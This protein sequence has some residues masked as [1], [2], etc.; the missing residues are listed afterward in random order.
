[1]DRCK[2]CI[3]SYIFLSTLLLIQYFQ[4]GTVSDLA[5][6]LEADM[7]EGAGFY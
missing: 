7:Y 2:I 4:N 6:G 5:G 1:M 3:L